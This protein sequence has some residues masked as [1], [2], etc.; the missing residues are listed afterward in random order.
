MPFDELTRATN[1]S[2]K[3]LE[4]GTSWNVLSTIGTQT[5]HAGRGGVNL[6]GLVRR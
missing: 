4:R 2:Q 5:I 6:S 3:S 1:I